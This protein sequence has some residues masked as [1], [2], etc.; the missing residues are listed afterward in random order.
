[1]SQTPTDIAELEVEVER[2]PASQAKVTVTAPA[3]EVDQAVSRA[4]AQLSRQVRLPG[5]RPGKAPAAV[6]ERAVGWEAIRQETIDLLLPELFQR[7][8]SQEQLEP[9][10]QPNVG[11]VSLERGEPFR[12]TS[13]ST[14]TT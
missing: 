1:M 7:A 8:V 14:V 5:F 2:L 11:E 13:V 9:V 10:S 3:S 12:F 4:L 6:V